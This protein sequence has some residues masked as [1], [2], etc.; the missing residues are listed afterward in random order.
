ML[1]Q[2][3][4]MTSDLSHKL[5]GNL[6]SYQS[7]QQ[8]LVKRKTIVLQPPPMMSSSPAHPL[9]N[10]PPSNKNSPFQFREQNELLSLR[11]KSE[12]T[13]ATELTATKESESEKSELSLSS[14]KR[15]PLS[16]KSKVISKPKKETN[17]TPEKGKKIYEISRFFV[18]NYVGALKS[19]INSTQCEKDIID[20]L[21]CSQE[22][23]GT[24]KLELDKLLKENPKHNR[25]QLYKLIINPILNPI[26][27][28]FL[29]RKVVSWIFTS[30]KMQD[31]TAH[32]MARK[33]FLYLCL[34]AKEITP[35]NFKIALNFK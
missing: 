30:S 23:I 7:L 28:Y 2:P 13:M 4:Q 3:S 11:F 18:K 21:G 14:P 19:T 6:Q 34:K 1:V 10:I 25:M 29:R 5:N 32:L 8:I 35:F 15:S 27:Q 12:A 24:I 31:K 26:F 22:H 33:N 16:I 20:Y 17:G 9:L